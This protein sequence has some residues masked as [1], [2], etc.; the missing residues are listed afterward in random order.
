MIDSYADRW[1]LVTGASSGIGSAF[2]QELAARGMHLVITARR[3]DKLEE[4]AKELHTRHG[5]CVEIIIANL[6][7]PEQPGR[8]IVEIAER[9]LEIELLVNNAGFATVGE[10]EESERSRILQMLQLNIMTVTD[11]V[12][13]LLPGMLERGHGAIINVSSLSGLQPVAYMGAYAASKSYVLHFSEALWAELR[14]KGVTVTAACPGVTT[15]ELFE[16][17][18]VP[19]WLQ[20]HPAHDPAKVVRTSLKAMEKRKQYVI[21]G[22]KNYFLACLER[23]ASRK[24]TVTESMRYFR[25]K[26]TKEKAN[27][28]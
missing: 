2:A 10:F 24:M 15:T 11:L 22:W 4:L 19:G 25:P 23:F 1:A 17:A 26:R 6:T 18:G 3:R 20:K 14:D 27:S 7:D 16:K 13:Q 5:T 21:V 28:E 8:L 12:Y 9:G